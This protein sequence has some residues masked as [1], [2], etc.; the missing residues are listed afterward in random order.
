RGS[1]FQAELREPDPG[2][3]LVQCG[4]SSPLGHRNYLVQ[5]VCPGA[6][7]LR[8]GFPLSKA[9]CFP[10]IQKLLRIHMT[11]QLDQ[12]GDY[13]CPPGLVAGAQTSSVIAVEV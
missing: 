11:E 5:F 10:G 3:D 8:L 9:A 13:T 2:I 12:L 6:P 4:I 1:S 7:S